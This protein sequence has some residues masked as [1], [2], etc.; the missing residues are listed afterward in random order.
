MDLMDL[1]DNWKKIAGMNS[2][3]LP[4]QP[5]QATPPFVPKPGQSGYQPASASTPFGT[6]IPQPGEQGY[7]PSTPGT[8]FGTK[9]PLQPI[10]TP[11]RAGRLPEVT[12]PE[13]EKVGIDSILKEVETPERDKKYAKNDIWQMQNMD[14][15]WYK[16]GAFMTELGGRLGNAFGGLTT[17]GNSHAETMMNAQKIKDA[18]AMRSS[19][20]SM[21]YLIENNPEM[22]E[23]LL[24]LPP[25]QRGKFMQL[26]LAQNAGL[27]TGDESA[28]SEKVRM[29]KAANPN[30]TDAEALDWAKG[31]SGTNVT[32]NNGGGSFADALGTAGR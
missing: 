12:V 8:P 17:R 27:T 5:T 31:G 6:K 15:P 25:E 26:A 20:K 7:Q 9:S 1:L 14:R 24:A 13:R 22:A 23:K 21:N 16:D 4:G 30:A 29:Y 2:P 11:N 32:V 18:Q 19:N 10:Q 28:F 3:M